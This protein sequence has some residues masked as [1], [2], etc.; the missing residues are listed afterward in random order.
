MDVKYLKRVLLAVVTAV[1]SIAFAVYLIYHFT[2]SFRNRMTTAA[3]V[4]ISE[5]DSFSAVGYIFR[6]E[7][8]FTSSGG[9]VDRLYPDGTKVAVGSKL[10]DVYSSENDLILSERIEVI[11]R[12]IGI[13]KS[14]SVS[15]THT[16]VA[17]LSGNIAGD[18]ESIR[19]SITDGKV[20]DAVSLRDS[21][22]IQM[23]KLQLL[24]GAA[25]SFDGARF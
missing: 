7:R 2:L 4:S 18:V 19:S 11:D 22:L 24:T 3:A 5:S 14:S 1:V 12:K 15:G 17:Q 8:V 16:D 6:D 25:D 13:L 21:L 9:A 20:A 10:I 23:N